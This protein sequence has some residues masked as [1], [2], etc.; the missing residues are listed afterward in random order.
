MTKS[1][2]QIWNCNKEKEM[3]SVSESIKASNFIAIDTEFPG[4]LKQTPIN[5]SDETRYSDMKIIGTW[6]VNFSDFDETKDAQNDKSI[7]FLRRN[8]LNLEKIRDQGVRIDEFFT[9]FSQILKKKKMTWVTFDGSYDMAYLLRAVTGNPLPENSQGFEKTVSNV[10]GDHLDVKKLSGMCKGLSSRFGLQR[11]ANE[12]EIRRVGEAHHAGSDSELTAK[13]FTKMALAIY[14]AQEQQR[15]R[16]REEHEEQ[17][18]MVKARCFL[19]L[20]PPRPVMM[21]AAY[22]SFGCFPPVPVMRMR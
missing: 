4:Y 10:F 2:G 21:F 7:E 5:A 6:E 13:V 15:K 8:G 12:L 19:P 17:D 14:R 1:D 16:V 18:R 11:V 9:E 22:P 20:Y 3:I